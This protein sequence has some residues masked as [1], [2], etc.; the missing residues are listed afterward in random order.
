MATAPGLIS[1]GMVY[2]TSS[3]TAVKLDAVQVSEERGCELVQIL[4]LYVTQAHTSSFH[5]YLYTV[6]VSLSTVHQ[7]HMSLSPS[8]Q[9]SIHPHIL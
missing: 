9:C 5:A 1:L 4:P 8:D 6:L 7:F 2:A 3:D